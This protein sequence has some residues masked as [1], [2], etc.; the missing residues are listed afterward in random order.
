MRNELEYSNQSCVNIIR[1]SKEYRSKG[2]P[3]I[4]LKNKFGLVRSGW[5]ILLASML[6]IIFQVL[7]SLPGMYLHKEIFDPGYYPWIEL[8]M[9]GGGVAGALLSSL[10][11]WKYI[12]KR[13]VTALGLEFNRLHMKDFVFGLFLGGASMTLIFIALLFTGQISLKVSL[14]SP[15]FSIYTLTF[16]ILFI[17][18]GFSEEIFFRGYIMKTMEDRQN[19][20]WLL[21]VMSALIFS[22]FHGMNPNVSVF[23]LINIALVGLLFSYMYDATKSLSMPIGYHITWNYFQGNVFG[24]PVSGTDPHGLYQ[25]TTDSSVKLFTGGNF[26]PE[27]GL[28]ATFLIMVGVFAT[29]MYCKKRGSGPY[30]SE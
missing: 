26:G 10:L 18:V 5:L 6:M 1:A 17:F 3:E 23:G 4:I 24:F 14:L 19:S 29:N 15:D 13:K 12:N 28:L 2:G 9:N 7:F 16:L 21:Y 20:K 27:G 30:V 11:I 25:I 8:L 22:L